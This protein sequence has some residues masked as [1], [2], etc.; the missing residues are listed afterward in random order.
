MH[1]K[2]VIVFAI[3]ALSFMNTVSAYTFEENQSAANSVRLSMNASSNATLLALDVIATQV[4]N[5][6]AAAFDL[7]FNSSVLRWAGTVVGDANGYAPGTFFGALGIYDIGYETDE[8]GTANNDKLVAGAISQ[9]NPVSGSGTIMTVKFLIIGGTAAVTF[10]NNN[11]IL[12]NM[13]FIPSTWLGG[14]FVGNLIM[15]ISQVNSSVTANSTTITWLT[16]GLADSQ[17]EYGTTASYGSLTDVNGTLTTVHSATIT[18][19]SSS[20]LYHFRVKSGNASVPTTV[21][22]DYVF[23]TLS[24]LDTTPPSITSVSASSVTASSAMITWT[25]NEAADS[26]VEYGT[27]ISYGNSTP[28]DVNKVTSHLQQISGLIASTSYHYRVKSRDA[29]GNINISSDYSFVTAAANNS[30]VI[31]IILEGIVNNSTNGK[32]QIISPTNQTLQEKDFTSNST[33][34]FT[35]DLGN[36]SQTINLKVFVSG[37]LVRIVSNVNLSK[38]S[39]IVFPPLLPGDINGD[40]T[41]NSL[42]FS[43]LNGKWYQYDLI[44][45]LNRDGTVNALDFSLM[46]K[47]WQK[48]GE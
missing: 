7:D 11:L 17:V 26:Q 41:V 32:L 2:N 18:G 19:L 15:I 10:S 22:E 31:K 30:M 46:N 12:T 48:T 13:S 5:V 9:N 47:N 1:R 34:G 16:N 25:T 44:A 43:I 38:T 4:S 42:D 29:A 8:N 37:Y 36:I 33:G 27:N 45:D 35:V 28:L 40:N 24:S 3:F 39:I 23:T 20:T 6:Y 21:S 14:T